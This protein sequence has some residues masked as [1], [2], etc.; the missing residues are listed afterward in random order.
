MTEP[1]SGCQHLNW[2]TNLRECEVQS[3]FLRVVYPSLKESMNL[4]SYKD[5]LSDHV[6]YVCLARHLWMVVTNE[7]AAVSGLR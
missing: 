5:G 6:T 3:W 1:V 7:R 2:G 4:Y